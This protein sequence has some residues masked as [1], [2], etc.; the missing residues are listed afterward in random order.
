[1][2]LLKV[3]FLNYEARGYSF[4]PP[5]EEAILDAEDI[6]SALP[7]ESR[8]SEPTMFVVMKSGTKLTIIGTPDSLLKAVNS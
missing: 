7:C 3:R 6:S 8:S 1:M 4:C 2:K 5:T